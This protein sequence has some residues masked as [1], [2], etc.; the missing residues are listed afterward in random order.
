MIYHF[1]LKNIFDLRIDSF[2]YIVWSAI[3][4][5]EVDTVR[6]KVNDD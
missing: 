5:C 1:D 4:Y 6:K 3:M 2:E